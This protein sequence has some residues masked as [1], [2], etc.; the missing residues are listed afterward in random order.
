MAKL[1]VTLAFKVIDGASRGIQKITAEVAKF[2][3]VAE[4][5]NSAVNAPF[6]NMDAATKKIKGFSKTAAVIGAGMTA[7]L[8]YPILRTGEAMVKS[9]ADYELAMADLKGRGPE[10]TTE[11]L[12][13]MG[14]AAR[15][16]GLETGVG[17]MKAIEGMT[18]LTMAGASAED[19]LSG[20]AKSA[21]LMSKAEGI[22]TERS[23][24]FLSDMLHAFNLKFSDSA[25]VADVLS[26]AAAISS[27]SIQNMGDSMKY[28]AL[29]AANYG[30]KL[31]DVAAVFATLGNLG[32][33]GETAGTTVRALM[34]RIGGNK[35]VQD[36][37]TAKGANPDS[38]FMPDHKTLRS[39]P[40]IFEALNK[41]NL[42]ATDFQDIFGRLIGDTIRKAVENFA[43][44]RTDLVKVEKTS[45]GFL[46]TLANEK[47]NTF[48]GKVDKL[49]ATFTDIGIGL[50]KDGT[51]D[52]LGEF[53]DSLNGLLQAFNNLSPGVKTFIFA[54]TGIV[55]IGGPLLIFF[56]SVAT[57]LLELIVVM[58][59]T[60]VTVGG[61]A[62]SFGAIGVAI[63]AAAAAIT[64]LIYK[65]DDIKTGWHILVDDMKAAISEFFDFTD[66]GFDKIA[67]KLKF[68]W[69]LTPMGMASSFAENLGNGISKLI[70]GDDTATQYHPKAQPS[71]GELMQRLTRPQDF[72][73][74]RMDGQQ[75]LTVDFQNAP[76]GT[77][78]EQAKT[79]G[80]SVT[81]LEIGINGM[82]A[83]KAQKKKVGN[84]GRK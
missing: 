63:L 9:A 77:T 40:E 19:V 76:F 37:L 18:A 24:E 23:A 45:D 75:K 79:L 55:F 39:F 29:G 10:A 42:S 73:N 54:L 13:Q 28:G 46:Q 57:A 68:L 3:K 84:G 64:I 71:G 62:I 15:K 61:L 7:A 78:I 48:W 82:S 33:K 41:L 49:K 21:V 30:L 11:Q 12:K 44:F 35:L 36:K 72:M 2:N 32:I 74:M 26:K 58:G 27:V 47:I 56:S 14:E 5:S 1:P 51:L 65:W 67:K 31:E 66:L 20:A 69:N 17:A 34:S 53:V 16:M 60:V 52:K 59:T 8:T 25:H 4:K 38:F 43:L 83:S 70:E 81:P 50:A 6:A 22:S 80:G